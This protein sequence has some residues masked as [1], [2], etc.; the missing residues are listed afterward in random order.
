MQI[1]ITGRLVAVLLRLID[2]VWA[3]VGHCTRCM[4]QAFLA[5][6]AASMLAMLA[7]AVSMPASVSI[8]I[9]SAAL[10]LT[11]FW[12]LHLLVFATKA[13]HGTFFSERRD[14]S[15]VKD[16]TETEHGVAPS[17]SRREMFSF[18]ARTVAGVAVGTAVP[19]VF[20]SAFGKAKSPCAKCRGCWNCC[21]CYQQECTAAPTCDIK[22]VNRCNGIYKRCIEKC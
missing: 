9:A 17:R 6:C 2:F 21:T 4:R 18:F 3:N 16:V 19:A 11:L 12:V 8:L 13:T 5:A 15:D 14:Q 1:K 22:C 20:S 10:G 7:W